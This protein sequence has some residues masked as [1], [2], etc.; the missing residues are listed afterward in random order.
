MSRS[1]TR[2]PVTQIAQISVILR[3][4]S[5]EIQRQ[6]QGPDIAR[7]SRKEDRSDLSMLPRM[8]AI[9][10]KRSGSS[11]GYSG[12][13]DRL[14]GPTFAVTRDA[15]RLHVVPAD[16]LD[17]EGNRIKQSS[18]LDAITSIPAGPRDGLQFL[19]AICD[20]LKKQIGFEIGIGPSVPSNN[21]EGYR[22][23]EGIDKMSAQ[24]AIERLLDKSSR[25]GNFVWDFVL[26]SR[27]QVLWS[28][29]QLRRTRQ[30]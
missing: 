4:K 5:L 20:E 14:A 13:I 30:L 7:S 1:H 21:L 16:V 10:T 27:R 23:N 22:T 26:R 6:Q 18:I 29:L 2:I 19:Q 9:P 8:S 24:T 11:P 17:A 12:N 3:L 15:N 25:T 28:E